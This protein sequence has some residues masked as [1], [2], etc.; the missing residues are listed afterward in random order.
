MNSVESSVVQ[1]SRPHSCPTSHRSAY[2]A[3]LGIDR[4][5]ENLSATLI[6]TGARQVEVTIPDRPVRLAV[7]EDRIDEAFAALS[8]AVARGAVVTIFGDLLPIYTGET[9]G[10]KGCALLS[11]S[12]AGGQTVAKKLVRDALSAVRGVVK[13]QSGFLR[14]REGR[15]ELRLSLYLPVMHR[16]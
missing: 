13:K 8:E 7:E 2:Q 9:D 15:G 10:D 5:V 14:V 16:Q 4:V 6:R 12:V 1:M 11:V 3:C